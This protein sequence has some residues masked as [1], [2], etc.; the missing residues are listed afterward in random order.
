MYDCQSYLL[1]FTISSPA[2]NVPHLIKSS[3]SSTT[4][5]HHFNATHRQFRRQRKRNVVFY[6]VMPAATSFMDSKT[7]IQGKV[8]QNHRDPPQRAC[9]TPP[10]PF[11]HHDMHSPNH[12]V[13]VVALSSG[14]G[15]CP[16]SIQASSSL[17]HHH[18]HSPLT[19]TDVLWVT[20]HGFAAGLVFIVAGME[21]LSPDLL[22]SILAITTAYLAYLGELTQHPSLQEWM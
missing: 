22:T 7:C 15:F 5:P 18:H 9:Q 4:L 21:Y 1:T 10:F 6:L 3:P 16:I 19:G 17:T 12:L 8:I 20:L 14:M 13:F 2:T 11:P